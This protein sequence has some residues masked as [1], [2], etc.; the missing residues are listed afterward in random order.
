MYTELTENEIE[1]V[2][3]DINAFDMTAKRL[4]QY[5]FETIKKYFVTCIKDGFEY[6]FTSVDEFLS[7]KYPKRTSLNETEYVH[8]IREVCPSIPSEL[9]KVRFQD[10]ARHLIAVNDEEIVLS[11]R[12]LCC[13]LPLN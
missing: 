11:V 3:A 2:V 9:L 7:H 4:N 10:G 1:Q 5:K 12:S 13:T 8:A 6:W